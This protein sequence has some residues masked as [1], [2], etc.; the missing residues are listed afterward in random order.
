M[1]ALYAHKKVVDSLETWLD[2]EERFKELASRLQHSRIDDQTGAA[3]EFWGVSGL[4]NDKE[5]LHEFDTLCT[6]VGR[7][8]TDVLTESDSFSEIL[9]HKDPKIRWYRL[10]KN[11]STSYYRSVP[12]YQTEDDGSKGWIYA[13]TISNI[14]KGSANLCLWLEA[15]FPITQ[16]WYRTLYGDY[17]KEI[18]IGVILI[19]IS[20]IFAV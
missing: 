8:I 3:G 17:G 14:G 13:G 11:H 10:L 15:H 5:A 2:Y 18:V 6:I 20:A 7:K 12:G 16:P 1:A 9:N 19:I 4:T